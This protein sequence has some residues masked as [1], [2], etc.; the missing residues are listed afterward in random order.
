MASSST[1]WILTLGLCI[2]LYVSQRKSRRRSIMPLPPGPKKL[3]FIGSVL[4]VPTK[5]PWETYMAWSKEYDSD[6]LHLDLAGQSLIILCSTEATKDLLEKRSALYSD[7]PRLTMIVELM[8]YD[9]LVVMKQYGDEWRANRRLMNQD[10]GNQAKLSAFRPMQL[11]AAHKVLSVRRLDDVFSSVG[12]RDYI[13]DY[14]WNRTERQRRSICA[15][16]AV[17]L[18]DA[19]NALPLLKYVP[20][21]MP[22]F[23]RDAARWRRIARWSSILFPGSD[24]DSNSVFIQE[25]GIAS[26]SFVANKLKSISAQQHSFYTEDTIC[27]MAGTLYLGG[28]DTSVST[29]SSFFL[30][31]LAN[32]QAMW[33]AQQEIYFVTEG[34]RLPSLEDYDLGRMPYVGALVKEVLRWRNVGPLGKHSRW[35]FYQKIGP[36]VPHYITLEDEYRGYRIPANSIVIGNAWA[37]LHDENTYPDP[38]TFK[39]ERFLLPRADDKS[40]G[41]WTPLCPSQRQHLDMVGAFALVDIWRVLR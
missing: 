26:P 9:F 34:T 11:D 40:T 39:P 28:A 29:L 30:A 24:H 17:T 32:P 20:S 21:W 35:S 36:G 23:K 2:A 41:K 15:A 27:S 4:S 38:L 16:C 12:H 14:V 1:V 8:G 18:G 13:E 3:P 37:I 19:G 31:I 25:A 5:H 6:I 33:N 10:F 7:R 22:G